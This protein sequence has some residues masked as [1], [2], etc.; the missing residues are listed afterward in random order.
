M[1][2]TGDRGSVRVGR[3]RWNSEAHLYFLT[4]V[5]QGQSRTGIGFLGEADPHSP[6]LMCTQCTKDPE[7][8]AW[9]WWWLWLWKHNVKYKQMIYKDKNKEAGSIHRS[10]EMCSTRREDSPEKRPREN[11]G[12]EMSQ[13]VV[14]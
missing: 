4:L 13:R 11:T 1:H 6:A 14:P 2:Y 3:Y 7:S 12:Q 8:S 10:M 5:Q 9:G